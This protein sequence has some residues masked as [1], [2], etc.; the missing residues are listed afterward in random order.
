MLRHTRGH[1][2]ITT[3]CAKL[4]NMFSFIVLFSLFFFFLCC[5]ANEQEKKR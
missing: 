4:Q 1:D 3:Q 2:K 5:Y